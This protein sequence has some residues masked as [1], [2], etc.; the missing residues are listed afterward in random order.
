MI[1]GLTALLRSAKETL[2]SFQ[3]LVLTDQMH[4]KMTQAKERVKEKKCSNCGMMYGLDNFFKN[5]TYKGVIRLY[6]VCKGCCKIKQRLLYDTE[7]NIVKERRYLDRTRAR[8]IL[9]RAIKNGDLKKEPCYICRDI[10]TE[11]HHLIYKFPLTVIWLCPKH[12]NQ[13]HYDQI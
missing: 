5:G 12:H 4:N 2:A 1:P 6:T 13:T 3:F 8:R 10:D 11:A 7:K 9:Q